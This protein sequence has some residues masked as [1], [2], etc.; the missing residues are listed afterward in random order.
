M[1]GPASRATT[2]SKRLEGKLVYDYMKV[3]FTLEALTHIADIRFYIEQR[4]PQAAIH[5]AERIFAEADRLGEFPQLGRIGVVPG[6]YEW[7]VP[8]L[9]YIIVHE[10][11]KDSDAVIVVGIF[12]GSQAR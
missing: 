12:H 9:P 6:T 5:I 8:R 7:T 4:S 10:L 2:K 11:D 1:A 3:R